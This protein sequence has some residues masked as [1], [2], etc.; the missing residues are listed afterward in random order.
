MVIIFTTIIDLAIETWYAI[1]HTHTTTNILTPRA[2]LRSLS[3]THPLT[4]LKLL[5]Y[6]VKIIFS[7][8]VVQI[9]YY[10]NYNLPLNNVKL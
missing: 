4:T 9:L 1:A 5:S 8:F 10:V 3:L 6:L 2:V 7:S